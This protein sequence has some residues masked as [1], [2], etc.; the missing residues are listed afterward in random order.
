MNINCSTRMQ[1]KKNKGHKT[2]QEYKFIKCI[3]N[4][5][6]TYL[7]SVFGKFNLLLATEYHWLRFGFLKI[8]IGEE[9]YIETRVVDQ[10]DHHYH[11]LRADN[12]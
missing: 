11:N 8:N 7:I 9:W 3:N 1:G 6:K 5:Y 2:D 10:Y 4:T 12:N